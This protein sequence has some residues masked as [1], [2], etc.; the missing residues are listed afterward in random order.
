M[1]FRSIAAAIAFFADIACRD[2]DRLGF[3][4]WTVTVDETQPPDGDSRCA[5]FVVD[6]SIEQVQL[7]GIER[8]TTASNPSYPYAAALADLLEET[9]MSLDEAGRW[10]GRSLP[11]A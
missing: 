6:P 3:A 8:G 2:L 5:Y 10:P 7:I 11:T 4:T 1:R 9:C